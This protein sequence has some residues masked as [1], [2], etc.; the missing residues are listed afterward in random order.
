V[1]I[2]LPDVYIRP[3]EY[4]LYFHLSESVPTKTNYDVL[5]DLTP[6]LV[7]SAGSRR[8][9]ENFDPAHP[10]GIFSLPSR[11]TVD[12]PPAIRRAAASDAALA[13][14]EMAPTGITTRI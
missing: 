1:T 9:H 8:L 7:I 4:P 3:G 13:S 12:E 2:D 11:M 6:P 5:D 14:A 10:F